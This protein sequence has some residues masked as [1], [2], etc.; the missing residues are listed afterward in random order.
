MKGWTFAFRKSGPI[1]SHI[2]IPGLNLLIRRHPPKMIMIRLLPTPRNSRR[3][4]GENNG[5]KK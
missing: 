2:N 5:A 3:I 4:P 1:R